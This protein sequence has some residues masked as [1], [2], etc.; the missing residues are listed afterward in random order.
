MPDE[1]LLRADQVARRLGVTPHHI[2]RLWRDR[3]LPGVKL[4]PRNLRFR[5]ADVQE[6]QRL[7]NELED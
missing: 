2:R 6:Y 7:L 1:T 5:V 3:K 4:S